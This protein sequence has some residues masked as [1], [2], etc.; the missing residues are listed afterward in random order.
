MKSNLPRLIGEEIGHAIVTEATFE[1]DGHVVLEVS[2][3][4]VG[5]L[6]GA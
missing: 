4:F 6:F 3:E 5:R 2:R 1:I